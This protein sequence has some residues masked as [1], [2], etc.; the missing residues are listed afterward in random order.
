MLPIRLLLSRCSLLTVVWICF[1]PASNA[2]AFVQSIDPATSP[3]RQQT[4]AGD[5]AIPDQHV[6][7]SSND[8]NE[9]LQTLRSLLEK[10]QGAS[11]NQQLTELGLKYLPP[12]YDDEKKWGKSKEFKTL[13]PRSDPL[14]LNHGTWRKYH[15]VPVN[16]QDHFRIRLNNLRNEKGKVH[17]TLECDCRLQLEARQAKWVRGVQLYSV[18][19]EADADVT[20]ALD[21]QLKIGFDWKTEPVMVIEP[22][23]ENADITIH[24]FRIHRVSKVGGEFAQQ[25][26]RAARD[27]LDDHEEKNEAKLVDKINRQIEKKKDRL[28]IPLS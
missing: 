1:C 28:R 13:I 24:Q 11:I 9:D 22:K 7:P 8:P 12:N 20:L 19:A 27:W 5:E 17:F 26:T 6:Q 10:D 4:E 16:P 2:R 23:I 3:P 15:V 21:C 14:V 25:V 18:N